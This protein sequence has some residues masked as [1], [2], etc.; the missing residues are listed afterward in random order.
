VEPEFD[1]AFL[2]QDD[3]IL[4]LQVDFL[5]AGVLDAI[6]ER[7][8]GGAAIP[9]D[10]LGIGHFNAACWPDTCGSE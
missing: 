3:D 8:V 2:P 9:E 5:D 1:R 10:D 7:A 4:I 6:D